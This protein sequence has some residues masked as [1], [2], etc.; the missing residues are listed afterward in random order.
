[1][2]KEQW[3][4]V[5][6]VVGIFPANSG[7]DDDIDIYTHESRGE[8]LAVVHTLRRQVKGAGGDVGESAG[9]DEYLALADFIAPKESGVKDYLG[10]FAVTAGLGIEAVLKKFEKENDDY[11]I[12]MIKALADRLAE[13]FAERLHEMVRK[14]LW[15]YAPDERLEVEELFRGKY[16]GIRPAP[17]YPSCPDHTEKWGLFNWLQVEERVSIGLSESYMMV[18]GA[19]VSGYYF[20]HPGA[21]YFPVGKVAKDQVDDYAQRKGMAVQEI[22][23]WLSLAK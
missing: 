14:E 3:L 12:I 6:G 1:I 2:E 4:R 20:S 18:P 10:G 22:E 11:S 15:G 7:D 9:V 16:R 8:V 5:N 21:Q 17:G 13:A 19:S 23:K